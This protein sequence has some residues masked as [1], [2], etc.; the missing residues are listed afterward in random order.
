ML[1]VTL[2]SL[3]RCHTCPHLLTGIRNV[4][5]H[6]AQ[7]LATYSW[8]LWWWKWRKSWCCFQ[9]FIHIC[10][11]RSK[12]PWQDGAVAQTFPFS[13]ALYCHILGRRYS[14]H[15]DLRDTLESSLYY[16][17]ESWRKNDSYHLLSTFIIQEPDTHRHRGPSYVSKHTRTCAHTHTHT[18]TH[19]SIYSTIFWAAKIRQGNSLYTHINLMFI[20]FQYIFIFLKLKIELGNW[21]AKR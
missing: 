8:P 2:W 17:S 6:H 16:F 20:T 15:W 21:D 10:D 19:S 13:L 9:F 18:H 11:R 12:A 5:Q 3:S 4:K 14:Q 1:S 7:V